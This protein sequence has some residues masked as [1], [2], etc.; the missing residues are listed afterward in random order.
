MF[1][2]QGN[3]GRGIQNYYNDAPVEVGAAFDNELVQVQLRA[4]LRRERLSA[5]ERRSD[6][7]RAYG[8]AS[9]PDVRGGS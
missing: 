5:A 7:A 4:S 8:A 9:S 1:R 3:G 6:E 2:L